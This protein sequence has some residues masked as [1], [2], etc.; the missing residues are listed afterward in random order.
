MFLSLVLLVACV[1]NKPN[2]PGTKMSPYFP[3]DGGRQAEYNNEDPT[4]VPWQLVV[5]KIEPVEMVDEEE[6]VTFEWSNHDTGEIVGAVKWSASSG[7]GIKIHAF[8]VGTGDFTTFDTP[9]LVS[10]DD[11]LM[12]RDD[13]VTTE[14]NGYTFTATLVGFE[15]CTVDWGLDWEDCAH[16]NLD[17]GDGDDTTGPIFAGDYWLVQRY[18]PA[19]MQLTGYEEKWNL[20]HYDW[21]ADE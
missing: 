11:D 1:D 17:D 10:D 13:T 12:L 8:S 2:F 5:E 16:I 15:D 4:G 21:D 18:G 3:M 6:V 9:V 19:W 14:T 20:A 7:D